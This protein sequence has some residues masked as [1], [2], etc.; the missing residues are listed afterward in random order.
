VSDSV[1][2][3]GFSAED[4]SWLFSVHL[5]STGQFLETGYS[6]IK[7][8]TEAL[9]CNFISHSVSLK[10]QMP[11]IAY[12]VI[13]VSHKQRYM[14]KPENFHTLGCF[15]TAVLI[16]TDFKHSVLMSV[17][18]LYKRLYMYIYIYIYIYAIYFETFQRPTC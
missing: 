17:L 13:T 10:R 2:Q 4:S 6:G 11:V 16:P 18:S 8:V 15:T 9:I 3:V 12:M 14:W 1:A 5:Q 7:N